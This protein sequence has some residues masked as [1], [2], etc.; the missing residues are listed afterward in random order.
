MPIYSIRW[1]GW[2]AWERIVMA[3]PHEI[4]RQFEQLTPNIELL[5]KLWRKHQQEY[6]R[7]RLRTIRL[8]W[9]GYSRQ[10]IIDLLDI[11]HSS[12]IRWMRMLVEQ[13]VDAGLQR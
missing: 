6:L 2:N 7:T 1:H 10:E 8:L 12:I 5:D 9:Q 3:K 11:G 4:T 13:G